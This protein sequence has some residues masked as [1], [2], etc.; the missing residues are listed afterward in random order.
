[1][2]VVVGW[3][4]HWR[5]RRGSPRREE[6][7]LCFCDGW[8]IGWLGRF[9]NGDGGWSLD[10]RLAWNA[11]VAEGKVELEMAEGNVVGEAVVDGVGSEAAAG[12]CD[13]D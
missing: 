9:G 8:W 1:M 2:W 12:V 6:V 4:W 10:S 3:P 13:L 7:R 5:L 11:R